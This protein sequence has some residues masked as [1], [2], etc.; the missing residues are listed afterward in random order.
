MPP[1]GKNSKGCFGVTKDKF[2]ENDVFQSKDKEDDK[3]IS[4]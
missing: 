2:Y 1:H 4:M 3:D